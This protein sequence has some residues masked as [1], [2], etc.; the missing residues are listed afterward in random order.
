M[1]LRY[2]GMALLVNVDEQ[3]RTR[4]A[5]EA[6]FKYFK[7]GNRRP[8]RFVGVSVFVLEYA[9]FEVGKLLPG[10]IKRTF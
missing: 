10:L 8:Q 3:G 6:V 7:G 4:F 5:V 9:N 1:K 2:R